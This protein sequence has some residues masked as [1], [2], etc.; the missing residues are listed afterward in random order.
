MKKIISFFKQ[1]YYSDRVAFAF[2]MFSTVVIV[3]TSIS[4]AVNATNPD[5]KLIYPGFFIGST[6]AMY[7]YYRRG[8]AWPLMLTVYFSCINVFGFFRAMGLI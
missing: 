5:M 7:A 1:S 6:A 8:L 2:E 4:L 3:I